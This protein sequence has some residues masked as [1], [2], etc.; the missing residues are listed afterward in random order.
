MGGGS[1]GSTTLGQTQSRYPLL[2]DGIGRVVQVR[3]GTALESQ[4]RGGFGESF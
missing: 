1:G 2:A 3:V 4:N